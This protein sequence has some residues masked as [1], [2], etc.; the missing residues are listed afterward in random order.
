MRKAFDAFLGDS[1]TIAFQT[2]DGLEK[3]SIDPRKMSSG[4]WVPLS[5][6]I[7]SVFLNQ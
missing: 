5:G 7:G 4:A 6:V 2:V 3:R 1:L